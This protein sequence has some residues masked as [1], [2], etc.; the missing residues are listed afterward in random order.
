MNS[1]SNEVAAQSTKKIKK[2][3]MKIS[4]PAICNKLEREIYEKMP[5]LEKNLQ[6][7]AIVIYDRRIITSPASVR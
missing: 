7:I 2:K 1:V 4:R 5:H 6:N 3:T